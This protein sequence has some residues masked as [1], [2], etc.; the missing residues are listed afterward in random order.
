[1]GQLHL[2][3]WCVHSPSPRRGC[4]ACA[5][6]PSTCAA[7]ARRRTRTREVACTKLDWPTIS[8]HLLD[9][10]TVSLQSSGEQVFRG[11]GEEAARRNPSARG[12]QAQLHFSDARGAVGEGAAG[13]SLRNVAGVQVLHEEGHVHPSYIRSSSFSRPSLPQDMATP[14]NALRSSGVASATER[15]PAS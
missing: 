4:S 15:H 13:R 12:A 6:S 5:P 9:W 1:M 8:L 14:S 10:P 2:S 11:D 7:R 3:L